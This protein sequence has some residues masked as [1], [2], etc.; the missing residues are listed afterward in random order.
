MHDVWVQTIKARKSFIVDL[1]IYTRYN[2]V[3]SSQSTRGKRQPKP[4]TLEKSLSSLKSFRKL[5]KF[6]QNGVRPTNVERD[7]KRPVLNK[8]LSHFFSSH[9]QIFFYILVKEFVRNK[10]GTVTLIDS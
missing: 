8:L 4:L 6:Q 9:E 3:M 10:K 1:P 2:H 7:G 5:T